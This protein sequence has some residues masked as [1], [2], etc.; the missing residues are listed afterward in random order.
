MGLPQYKLSARLGESAV[1][2]L[3][4]RCDLLGLL[5]SMI[6]KSARAAVWCPI[7]RLARLT[8]MNR[9]DSLD[10]ICS[11]RDPF[12]RLSVVRHVYLRT[13]ALSRANRMRNRTS[14]IFRSFHHH[15]FTLTCCRHHG[16]AYQQ[17]T[18]VTC[19]WHSFGIHMRLCCYIYHYP[20]QRLCSHC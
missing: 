15:L 11:M 1:S 9:L 14:C 6:Q 16:E 3:Y 10:C 18:S 2:A 20:M 5:D 19:R 4:S 17:N 7:A 8:R 12:D 13:R